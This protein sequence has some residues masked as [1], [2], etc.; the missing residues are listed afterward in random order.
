VAFIAQLWLPILASGVIVFI[1]SALVWTM[2]PHH[3]SEWRGAPNEAALMAAL[4]GAAPGLYAFPYTANEQ[5]RRSKAFMEKW[6]QGPA[7]HITIAPP[8][9]MN[10]GPMMVKALIFNI[11][12]AFFAAYIAGHVLPLPGAPYL[13]VFRVVGAIGF[14]AY[15]FATVPDSIWFGRPW[16]SWCLQAADALFYALMMA[17]TFGWLWPR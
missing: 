13:T 3:K 6:A 2:L 7:G 16:R 10:M 4:K 1:A 11:I 14:M 9:P 17:G 5:E 15:A 12:V 8:G